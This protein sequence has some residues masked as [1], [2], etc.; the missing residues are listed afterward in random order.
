MRKQGRTRERQEKRKDRR[1]I[2]KKLRAAFLQSF[3]GQHGE[4][5]VCTREMPRVTGM[6]REGQQPFRPNPK[7]SRTAP[8]C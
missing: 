2:L 8:P 5:M 7:G 6:A 4:N 3:R 1:P